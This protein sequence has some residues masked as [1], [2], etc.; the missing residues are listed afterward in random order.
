MIGDR[1][2][3]LGAI[4]QLGNVAHEIRTKRGGM[5]SELRDQPLA[6][7][8]AEAAFSQAL[9]IIDS[10]IHTLMTEVD[11]SSQNRERTESSSESQELPSRRRT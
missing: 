11:A 5:R 10:R 3:G 2:V 7:M 9:R 1:S 4:N 6:A 8:G